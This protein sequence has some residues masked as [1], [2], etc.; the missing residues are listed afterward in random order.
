MSATIA[1]IIEAEANRLACYVRGAVERPDLVGGGWLAAV[2]APAQPL[3]RLRLRI[4]GAMKDILR[5][6]WRAEGRVLNR[7]WRHEAHR[8]QQVRWP[9]YWPTT[10]HLS[11]HHVVRRCVGCRQELSSVGG[12]K[13]CPACN[14]L[15]R[16]HYNKRFRAVA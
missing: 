16:R 14:L 3:G 1:A 10:F 15:H 11:R 8:Y 2:T 12:R 4:R 6:E 9:V 13:R 5:Q 7:D